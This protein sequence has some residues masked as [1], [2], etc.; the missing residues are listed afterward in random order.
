M[1]AHKGAERLRPNV[2][3]VPVVLA[4]LA[5]AFFSVPGG[6]GEGAVTAVV[7]CGGA[8][9]DRFAPAAALTAPRHYTHNGYTLTVTAEETEGGVA[10]RVTS[11][12]CPGEDC[13]R[14]GAIRHAGE[15][16]VC[17]PAGI[18]ITLT[19]GA[20]QAVDAVTG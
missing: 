20:A 13:V 10:L 18:V 5:L 8:E 4:V 7:R 2:W 11:S 19:G 6:R 1:R 15:S 9:A 16:I 17:L 12:D 14:T 3:D